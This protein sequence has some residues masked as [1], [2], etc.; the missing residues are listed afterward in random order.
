LTQYDERIARVK[1]WFTKEITTRFSMPNGIDPNVAATDIIEGINAALPSTLTNEQ[2]DYLLSKS[3]TE[4]ARR[5]RSRT[6]PPVK[7]FLTSTG[8]VLKKYAESAGESHPQASTSSRKPTYLSITEARVRA[9]EPISVRW[10]TGEGRDELLSNTD[11]TDA[12]LSK[13]QPPTAGGK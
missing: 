11:L 2:L 4:L 9:G 7:D 10:L 12:D 13:Y 8:V 1:S 3:A 5:S 6:L